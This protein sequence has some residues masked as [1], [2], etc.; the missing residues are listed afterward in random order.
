MG[1]DTLKQK[2]ELGKRSQTNLWLELVKT[3]VAETE[4]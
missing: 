2:G 4:S 3:K 1:K